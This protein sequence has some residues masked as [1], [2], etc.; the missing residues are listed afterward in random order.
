MK[1]KNGRLILLVGK[2][3]SGKTTF[4]QRIAGELKR[5]NF[6]IAG[7][8]AL[9]IYRG[10]FLLGYDLVNI[11]SGGRVKFAR[12]KRT[13]EPFKFSDKSWQFGQAILNNK[14][15]RRAELIIIDEFGPVEIQGDGWRKCV[16][17][18]TKSVKALILLV[19]REES[20]E[21]VSRLYS[22]KHQMILPVSDLL[23][24]DNEQ[25]WKIIDE[26]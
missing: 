3:H 1:N 16:D 14:E 2:K 6:R 19:V 15:T 4:L 25:F 8:L 12:R 21:A 9:S 26:L 7:L 17:S 11:Q 5:K 23:S 22:Y 10:A 18:L 20:A 24:A 13:E